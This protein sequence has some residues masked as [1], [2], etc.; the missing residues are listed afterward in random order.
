MRRR[1]AN[2]PGSET[3]TGR[4]AR[5]GRKPVLAGLA[6]AGVLAGSLL[7]LGAI[8]GRD[9]REGETGDRDGYLGG[10]A[11][12]GCHAGIAEEFLRSGMG[13]SFVRMTDATAIADFKDG[14]EFLHA[15][16]SRHYRMWREDGSY[17]MRRWQVGSDGRE[18]NVVERRID[19][20]VAPAS[21]RARTCRGRNP[22]NSC[23][24]RWAGTASAA[25]LGDESGL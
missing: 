20:A 12:A 3:G 13:R 22:G 16:S 11:C 5:P 17:F 18:E 7:Y 1:S 2:R 24:C 8:G 23:S 14:N 10:A 15:A 25:D 6:A 19:Y 21:R 4:A 9:G